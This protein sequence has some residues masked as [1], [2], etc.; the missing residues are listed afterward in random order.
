MSSEIKLKKLKRNLKENLVIDI[1]KNT[2]PAPNL[3]SRF[4]QDVEAKG[5]YV[6]QG[7]VDMPGYVNGKANLRN[8]LFINVTEVILTK[9]KNE[10][11]KE[12]NAKGQ[13]LTDRLMNL[14]YDAIVTVLENGEYGE[15][16]LFPNA[17]FMLR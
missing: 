11:A 8:P 7:K 17:S 12:Y 2:E 16:V 14:G 5:T 4:G 6:I 15:I 10:L 1:T 9:Y 3:G 13:K